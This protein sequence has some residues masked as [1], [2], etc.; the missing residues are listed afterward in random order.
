MRRFNLHWCLCEWRR[1]RLTK[2]SK[3]PLAGLLK[4]REMNYEGRSVS[5]A[6]RR[7]RWL[8]SISLGAA[9]AL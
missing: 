7:Q 3:Q 6:R 8:S 5:E 4:D 1:F 9:S 2:R